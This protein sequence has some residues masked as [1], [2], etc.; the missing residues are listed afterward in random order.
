MTI[1]LRMGLWRRD[2]SGHPAVDELVHH[3]RAGSV[4]KFVCEGFGVIGAA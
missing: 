2:R 3:S 1:A 4:G